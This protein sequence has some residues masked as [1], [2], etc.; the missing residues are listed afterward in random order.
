MN[1]LDA[2]LETGGVT[3]GFDWDVDSDDQGISP[4]DASFW[5]VFSCDV[6]DA[7]E[8]FSR[9]TCGVDCELPGLDSNLD[10][11]DR[12]LLPTC[13]SDL[14]VSFI[15]LEFILPIRLDTS[16]EFVLTS[17]FVG[18]VTS[19]LQLFF[20]HDGLSRGLGAKRAAVESA[21]PL[22]LFDELLEAAA[23][24]TA[25]DRARCSR[26][27]WRRVALLMADLRI[28]RVGYDRRVQSSFHFISSHQLNGGEAGMNY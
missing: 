23:A 7:P 10:L 9:D 28:E 11:A 8:L 25:F 17:D 24:F 1:G 14:F 5:C 27:F 3:I 18:D 22:L 13:K 20:T 12:N 19:A 26:S 16:T 4:D 15:V 6:A 21:M 2:I